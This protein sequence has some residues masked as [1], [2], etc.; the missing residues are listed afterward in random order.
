MKKIIILLFVLINTIASAQQQV[1]EQPQKQKKQ[2]VKRTN[3]ISIN[4]SQPLIRSISKVPIDTFNPVQN[5]NFF[6]GKQSKNNYWRIGL[7]GIYK[8]IDNKNRLTTD[9]VTEELHKYSLSVS[10]YKIKN[11]TEKFSAGLGLT[12]YGS[13]LNTQNIFDSGFDNVK[14][15]KQSINGGIA[16]GLLMQ[17]QVSKRL[18]IFTE[19]TIP[20]LY[21]YSKSGKKFSAFPS[22]NYTNIEGNGFMV[23]LDFPISLFLTYTF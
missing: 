10:D 3:S 23:Q 17:Y 19:Y 1:V 12:L 13:F 6:I 14:I 2:R 16:P 20:M 5:A 7:G 15:Y 18:F 9:K 11:L 8:S 22:E 21:T 4:V